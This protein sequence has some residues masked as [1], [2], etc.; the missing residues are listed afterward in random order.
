MANREVNDEEFT[1]R[2]DHWKKIGLLDNLNLEENVIENG[3]Q[4]SGGQIQR[5]AL[6]RVLHRKADVY[7]FDE[8]SNSLDDSTKQLIR[9]VVD[10]EFKDKICIFIV[11]DNLLDDLMTYK[12][13]L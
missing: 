4:L 10:S 5:I 3:K 13:Q 1:R 11:H 8:F 2:I 6:A 7:I 9:D 12:Y